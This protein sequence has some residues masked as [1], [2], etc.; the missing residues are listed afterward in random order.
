MKSMKT[1]R[2]L[3]EYVFDFIM[4]FLAVTLSFF[5]ENIRD[6]LADRSTE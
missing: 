4:L 6:D 1:N 2:N 5:V 3:K